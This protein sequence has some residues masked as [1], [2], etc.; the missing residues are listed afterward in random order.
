MQS[1]LCPAM[2]PL[3]DQPH[4]TRPLPPASS[5]FQVCP[6]Q[7]PMLLSTQLTLLLQP[8]QTPLHVQGAA[9]GPQTENRLLLP[10]SAFLAHPHIHSV[11]SCV[12][13]LGVLSHP[14]CLCTLVPL[15]QSQGAVCQDPEGRW[16]MGPAVPSRSSRGRLCPPSSHSPQWVHLAIYE[17]PHQPR[18]C[19]CRKAPQPNVFSPRT[20]APAVSSSMMFPQ[21][22]LGL[23]CLPI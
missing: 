11:S 20:P 21:R 7:T 13:F 12:G 6:D 18:S 9:P 5:A 14:V 19:E 22:V 17:S 2:D 10:P 23:P 3:L 8:S 16:K 15:S 4:I 1:H